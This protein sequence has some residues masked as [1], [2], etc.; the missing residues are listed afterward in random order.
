MIHRRHGSPVRVG[1]LGGFWLAADGHAVRFPVKVALVEGI[2][3]FVDQGVPSFF[4]G[5][6]DATSWRETILGIWT[7]RWR[8]T[9]ARASSALGQ[10]GYQDRAEWAAKDIM[11]FVAGAGSRESLMTIL[12]EDGAGFDRSLGRGGAVA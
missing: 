12:S 9:V 7:S 5:V 2:G 8:C 11:Q 1:G 4:V 10:I 6:G 3:R